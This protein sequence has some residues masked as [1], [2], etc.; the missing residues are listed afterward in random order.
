MTQQSVITSEARL[1][2]SEA[3]ESVQVFTWPEI[4]SG[5]CRQDNGLMYFNDDG[6]GGWSCNTVTS[7]TFFRDV[8]H[9]N[10]DVTG[11]GGQTLFRLGQY[12]SPLMAPN[13]TV[14]WSVS[15]S[16]PVQFFGKI[17]TIYQHSSC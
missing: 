13:N 12:D 2:S 8:W 11:E 14:S 3:P 1:G 7:A 10:F 5:D 6:S 9:S 15:F 16:Y 17:T 4:H